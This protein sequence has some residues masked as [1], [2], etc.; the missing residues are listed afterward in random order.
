MMSRQRT[1]TYNFRLVC[2]SLLLLPFFSSSPPLPW[3][4]SFSF[5]TFSSIYPVSCSSIFSYSSSR[6]TSS[7]SFITLLSYL[8]SVPFF[9]IFL[10]SFFLVFLLL[11]MLPPPTSPAP[12]SD[13]PSRSREAPVIERKIQRRTRT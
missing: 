3:L 12:P 13:T 10:S 1:L 11:I 5:S 4:V 6:S 7:F 8:L 2:F 9:Y